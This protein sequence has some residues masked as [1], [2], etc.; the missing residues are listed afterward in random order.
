MA[1]ANGSMRPRMT[2]AMRQPSLP[3][4]LSSTDRQRAFAGPANPG[5][6]TGIQVSA[7]AAAPRASRRVH[8]AVRSM[9]EGYGAAALR[10][11][12]TP[13]AHPR[14]AVMRERT[15]GKGF[16]TR[17]IHAGEGPDPVTHAHNTPIYATAT[18]AFDT[19][20]DKE[21][22]VDRALEWDPTSYFYSRTGNPTNRALEEKVASLEGAEDCVGVGVGHGGRVRR[23]CSPISRR[24]TTS[25]WATSCSRSRRCCGRTTCRGAGS[26]SPRST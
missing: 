9:P 6:P 20:A 14:L 1:T 22:A 25:C 12:A 2:Y 10:G 26:R 16:A 11:R 5:A 18:F 8:Q 21:A 19:A 17:A 3:K 15:H 23:R 7:M 24:T 4:R 13:P